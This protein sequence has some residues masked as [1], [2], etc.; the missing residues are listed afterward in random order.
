MPRKTNAEGEV[1][2]RGFAFIKFSKTSGAAAAL[3]DL[4]GTEFE[5][6]TLR[7][8][9]AGCQKSEAG[10]IVNVIPRQVNF[11]NFLIGIFSE[12]NSRIGACAFPLWFSD[13]GR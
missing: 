4:D 13:E 3:E 1:L 12:T 9:V 10:T 11:L 6:H 2:Q 8:S 7:V 5:Q